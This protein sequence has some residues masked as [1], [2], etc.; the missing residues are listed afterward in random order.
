M[1]APCRAAIALI[2]A[3]LALAPLALPAQGN[4]QQRLPLVEIRTTEGRM[5]VALSNETPLH[6]DNFL[7][8]VREGFYDSTLFHRCIPGFL[9]Q[10]GDPESRKAAR[11]TALGNGGPGHDLPAE[12]RPGLYHRKGALVAAGLP[13]ATG[14][15]GRTSGSQFFLV[16]GRTWY[17][18]DLAV[19]E[20]QMNAYRP[21]S[22][23]VH[24]T[25]DM[26][27]VYGSE[28]GE[29]HL[30]GEG[31]VFGQVVEGLDVLEHVANLPC[32]AYDRPLNDVRVWMRVLE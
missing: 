9:I 12:V 18:E 27:A 5:V 8:L 20:A 29:P 11:N 3:V 32:D 22:S 23:H 25:P 21:D 1:R 17:P 7:K 13:E 26:V 31:T 28:G 14:T 30:D 4:M 6:R 15:T 2:G 19:L 10:G 16:Q 24:F